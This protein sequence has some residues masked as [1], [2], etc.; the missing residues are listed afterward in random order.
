M[1]RATSMPALCRYE[2][3]ALLSFFREEMAKR[4]WTLES[5]SPLERSP[6]EPDEA[7]CSGQTWRKA[8]AFVLILGFAAPSSPDVA[9]RHPHF[10]PLWA[11]PH[12]AHRH[13]FG[14]QPGPRGSVEDG[15]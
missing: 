13:L 15:R 1:M 11:A 9:G 5:E 6:N 8:D 3:F 12:G 7:V 10:H 2:D 14:S 4:G